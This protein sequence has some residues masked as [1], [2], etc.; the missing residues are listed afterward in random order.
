[1]SR[2]STL[3]VF[4][5]NITSEAWSDLGELNVSPFGK[6]DEQV[7]MEDTVKVTFKRLNVDDDV[8]K[9]DMEDVGYKLANGLSPT[10]PG[11]YDLFITERKLKDSTTDEMTDRVKDRVVMNKPVIW[12]H[13]ERRMLL[14]SDALKSSHFTNQQLFIENLFEEFYDRFEA[15]QEENRYPDA[16]ECQITLSL[17]VGQSSTGASRRLDW[18]ITSAVEKYLLP[19]VGVLQQVADIKLHYQVRGYVEMNV[20]PTELS[21]GTFGIEEERL[22]VFVDENRWNIAASTLSSSP[23]NLLLFVPPTDV[24]PIKILSGGE[25]MKGQFFGYK[26]WGGVFILNHSD[27]QMIGEED[28]KPV[29]AAFAGQLKRLFGVHLPPGSIGDLEFEWIVPENHK[30]GVTDIEL[31]AFICRKI[32]SR[33]SS[34][35]RTLQALQRLLSQ[36][37]EI[38]VLPAVSSLVQNAF[39]ALNTAEINLSKGHWREALLEV[40]KAT[41]WSDA[42]FFHPTM[43]SHQYF[44]QEH[45]L[46]V[47]MPLFFPFILPLVVATLTSVVAWAKFRIK[48]Q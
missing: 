1:M 10:E 34:A 26:Q 5:V 28:L 41:Q 7:E 43:M 8:L 18:N 3:R 12:I 36:Y 23:I 31:D 11:Q 17:A 22:P 47:Y 24:Q 15:R 48:K 38:A 16:I 46:G 32:K 29:M 4:L 2:L 9:G 39:R 42:A 21:D 40:T 14:C 33:V 44:P 30:T 35:T 27:G 19:L 13:P 6:G 20:K 45:K 25:P 37:T